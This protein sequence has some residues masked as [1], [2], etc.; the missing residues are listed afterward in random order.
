MDNQDVQNVQDMINRKGVPPAP[1]PFIPNSLEK[2]I[3]VYWIKDALIDEIRTNGNTYYVTISYSESNRF[4]SQRIKSI[5]L[6]VSESVTRLYDQERRSIYP[7]ELA[8]GMIIDALVG[9][10]NSTEFPLQSI[11]YQI[12][13]V[14]ASFNR[15]ATK[16]KVMQA[17]IRDKT[18]IIAPLDDPNQNI[19]IHLSPDAVLLGEFGR[20]I[21]F[22]DITPGFIVWVEH[23]EVVPQSNPPQATGYLVRVLSK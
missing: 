1:L 9:M 14:T 8:A 5:E 18:F 2:D 23:E 10:K 3:E 4:N 13:V 20:K 6:I 21:S 16:G 12:L 17:N 19:R 22:Q 7:I 11:A 15:T